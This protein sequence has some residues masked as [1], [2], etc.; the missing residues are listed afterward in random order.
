MSD[1]ADCLESIPNVSEGRSAATIEKL[2]KAIRANP[3]VR[4]LDT[5]SDPHH[6]RTVFTLVSRSSDALVEAL[7]GLYDS[8]TELIDLASH[9]G[10]HPRLGVVD[11]CPF[12][13][14]GDLDR[15]IALDAATTLGARVGSKLHVP[16]F[17]YERS[18]TSE[19]ATRLPAIR[20]GGLDELGRQMH[21]GVHSPDF[22]P[23][24][25]HP[26]A[27]VS[28]IGVRAPL[29]A[30]NVQLE[31]GDTTIARRIARKIR[32]SSGGL[33]AVRALGI[34]LGEVAQVSMNLIDY[35]QTTPLDALI[36]IEHAANALGTRVISSELVGLIPE[37]A[38]PGDP[39]RLKIKGFSDAMI[40]ER[41]L[42]F[43]E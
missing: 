4:L 29:I 19:W 43:E 8:A 24:S 13:P 17:L 33:P 32:T 39:A 15:Q 41:R 1:T 36:A 27:G 6:N 40:L 12:V 14:L 3:E 20:R 26:T 35:R 2:R 22:G 16:V 30:F 25:P 42:T 23:S 38:L 5:H 9:E 21:S 11:V 10:A 31:S 37:A 7:F 28:V 18:A 34:Q